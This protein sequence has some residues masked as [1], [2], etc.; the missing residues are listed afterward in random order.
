MPSLSADHFTWVSLTLDVGYVFKAGPTK[1]TCCSLP[2][3]WGMSSGPELLTLHVGYLLSAAGHSCAA[4]LL[5]ATPVLNRSL[6]LAFYVSFLCTL[7]F[8]V[9]DV[10]ECLTLMDYFKTIINVLKLNSRRRVDF[11]RLL[12]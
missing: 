6:K 8:L 12:L 5:L 2:W 10:L 9:D 1:H 7:D 11:I 3:M 4:Q